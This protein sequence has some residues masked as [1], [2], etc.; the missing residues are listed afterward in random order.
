MSSLAVETKHLGTKAHSFSTLRFP[1]RRLCG[2]VQLYFG[3][4][5]HMDYSVKE[6]YT[7][8]PSFS[9]GVHCFK[10]DDVFGDIASSNP[11]VLASQFYLTALKFRSHL[12]SLDD[13]QVGGAVFLWHSANEELVAA[14][15]AT[16]LFS[17]FSSTIH[18][19]IQTVRA[20]A[21]TSR[22]YETQSHRVLS[23]GATAAEYILA[24]C[25]L[26]RVLATPVHG[27]VGALQKST[28][29][30][31]CGCQILSAKSLAPQP[32]KPVSIFS[33]TAPS[34]EWF[35][36]LSYYAHRVREPIHWTLEDGNRIM[37]APFADK[38]VTVIPLGGPLSP[39]EWLAPL[40]N[41]EVDSN[42]RHV[43]L[44]SLGFV[45][46]CWYGVWSLIRQPSSPANARHS[47]MLQRGSVDTLIRLLSAMEL[48]PFSLSMVACELL[49]LTRVPNPSLL[50]TWPMQKPVLVEFDETQKSFYAE[51]LY[52]KAQWP[53]KSL[54][55]DLRVEA[56]FYRLRTAITLP[57][58]SL[59]RVFVSGS[60]SA[61]TYD[62]QSTCFLRGY[63]SRT[64]QEYWTLDWADQI[65]MVKNS[66]GQQL[67]VP[68]NGRGLTLLTAKTPVESASNA[69]FCQS[70]TDRL[71]LRVSKPVLPGER[72]VVFE[73][74]CFPR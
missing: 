61:K 71:Y 30:R 4:G 59:I 37:S 11:D 65:V 56:G 10:L 1:D 20:A 9:H 18:D 40:R 50:T 31:A 55:L 28:W 12:A 62:P 36:Y 43:L 23:Y 42:E 51:P 38:S 26:P 29:S 19:A 57:P 32:V 21:W 48:P 68:R 49:P 74:Q 41:F 60:K 13:H 64:P 17:E 63:R 6:F 46:M 8:N 27:T 67:P 35:R 47:F 53:R 70:G 14:V 34:P 73:P 39:K 25:S 5:A 69:T 22:G 52:C 45:L 3:G 66:F 72:L 58:G 16:I 44:S 24:L 2:Q 15:L 7:R 54:P 33:T